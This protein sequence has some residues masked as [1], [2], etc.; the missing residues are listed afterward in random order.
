[1]GSFTVT[2]PFLAWQ[3]ILQRRCY[4]NCATGIVQRLA[5]P[6]VHIGQT[7]CA[8]QRYHYRYSLSSVVRMIPS[9]KGRVELAV[10][11]GYPAHETPSLSFLPLSA[12]LIL[13]Y[14]LFLHSAGDMAAGSS[15]LPPL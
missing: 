6:L 13:S 4:W 3:R 7:I 9:G 2:H 15:V 1:M 14:Q 5:Q 12:S 10:G 8:H 11:T